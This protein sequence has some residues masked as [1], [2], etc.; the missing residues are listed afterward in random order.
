MKNLSLVRK[1]QIRRVMQL[2]FMLALS[3]RAGTQ[4]LF[5]F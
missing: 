2:V 1:N 5:R 4:L 3:F